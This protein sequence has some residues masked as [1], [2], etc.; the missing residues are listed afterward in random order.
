[1]PDTSG[2]GKV[3]DAR[4]LGRAAQSGTR[5]GQDDADVV[6]VVG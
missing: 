6:V 1:M 4:Q 5:F 3:S 2:N